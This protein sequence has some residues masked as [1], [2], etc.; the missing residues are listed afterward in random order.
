[1]R[2]EDDVQHDVP[3][4]QGVGTDGSL[5]SPEELAVEHGADRSPEKGDGV[6]TDGSL[7]NPEKVVTDPDTRNPDTTDR[8]WSGG[9]RR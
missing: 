7:V 6:G 2:H 9:E 8:D 1:M 3:G 5:R 4:G